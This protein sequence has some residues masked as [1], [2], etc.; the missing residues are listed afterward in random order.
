MDTWCCP[1]PPYTESITNFYPPTHSYDNF[2]QDYTYRNNKNVIKSSLIYRD[3]G[4]NTSNRINRFYSLVSQHLDSIYLAPYHPSHFSRVNQNKARRVKK[5][6]IL[7]SYLERELINSLALVHQSDELIVIAKPTGALNSGI[8]LFTIENGTQSTENNDLNDIL[9]PYGYDG[10][11]MQVKFASNGKIWTCRHNSKIYVKELTANATFKRKFRDLDILELKCDNKNTNKSMVYARNFYGFIAL[12]IDLHSLAPKVIISNKYAN[13]KIYNIS[14][15]PYESGTA[16]LL[17]KNAFT[18]H[19]FSTD[20][21]MDFDLSSNNLNCDIQT[22]TYGS[23]ANIILMG[24]HNLYIQD[25]RTKKLTQPI[26]DN[27]IKAH[28]STNSRWSFRR[29]KNKPLYKDKRYFSA[30]SCAY[31]NYYRANDN[32]FWGAITAIAS[33]P[34]HANIVAFVYGVSD[35]IYIFDLNMPTRPL[36][37]LPITNSVH[38][39]SR[40][41]HIE[42]IEASGYFKWLL[43]PFNW[44]DDA[45]NVFHFDSN[46]TI[47]HPK[48]LVV[49]PQVDVL[50]ESKRFPNYSGLFETNSDI[51][52]PTISTESNL[53][54]VIFHG[55]SGITFAKIDNHMHSLMSSTSGRLIDIAYDGHVLDNYI[56]EHPEKKTGKWV[57]TIEER[58][59]NL[60]L[61]KNKVI[62]IP[63]DEFLDGLC[64]LKVKSLVDYNKRID[65]P[66]NFK[67]DSTLTSTEFTIGVSNYKINDFSDNAIKQHYNN[68]PVYDGYK[69]FQLDR[70]KYLSNYSWKRLEK[71]ER[72]N[73]KCPYAELY[74]SYYQNVKQTKLPNINIDESNFEDDL[75]AFSCNVSET[76]GKIAVTQPIDVVMCTNIEDIMALAD[77]INV[78]NVDKPSKSASD[79][80]DIDIIAKITNLGFN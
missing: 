41:R 68:L 14:V 70:V 54:N 51:S 79:V 11:H 19:S 30:D 60:E 48:H 39:G 56:K 17:N 28:I 77:G 26:I 63:D 78:E 37:E 34:I 76:M 23:S 35:C 21:E 7:S 8:S 25:I 33:H 31:S 58:V 47:A 73:Q 71:V 2:Q 15:S 5:P 42:W 55:Y 57:G 46:I 1:T 22:I 29:I 18:I 27:G 6:I 59:G 45:I 3:C 62:S 61:Q 36:Y 72:L 69:Y 67:F 38:I 40:C 50:E 24:S 9:Q 49:Y 64:D 80:L 32:L 75:Q 16:I 20:R 74:N 10:F 43:V 12:S 65:I 53:L 44:R 4:P 52:M 13:K 66:S